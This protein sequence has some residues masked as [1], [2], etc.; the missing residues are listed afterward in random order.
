MIGDRELA[1]ATRCERRLSE[2][3][4]DRAEAEKAIRMVLRAWNGGA[5]TGHGLRQELH[6]L[7]GRRNRD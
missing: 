5:L 6:T 7:T 2:V 1:E 3:R 4:S